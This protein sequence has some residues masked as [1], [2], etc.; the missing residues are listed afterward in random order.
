[1]FNTYIHA[2]NEQ[3]AHG[4]ARE[5]TYRTPFE[6]LLKALAPQTLPIHEGKRTLVGT[7]DFRVL[8]DDI[9]IGVIEC[10]DIGKNLDD[11][12]YKDQFEKYQNLGNLIITD[13]LQFRWVIEGEERDRVTIAEVHDGKIVP[14]ADNFP[15]LQTL[16]NGFLDARIAIVTSASDLAK[17]L[18]VSA[19]GIR[20]R[21]NA[22]LKSDHPSEELQG[23]MTAFREA[24]LPD[25]TVDQFAD[26]FAQT[27]VYGV[28][29]ARVRY[30]EEYP[31]ADAATDFP[32]QS[33]AQIIPPTNPFLRKLFRHMNFDLGPNVTWLM[34]NVVDQLALTQIDEIMADFGKSTAQHDPVV[35]FYETFLGEYDAKLREQRGVYYTPE[36]VVSYIVRSVD[37]ILKTQ[38]S[39]PD[40]LADDNTLILDPATG[41]GTFLHTV[42]EHIHDQF[43]QHNMLGEW[44]AYVRDHLLP[45]IFG[46]E[47][48]MAPYTVAHMKLG[49]QLQ[50]TGYQFDSD[51]R[52]GI[53]LTNTLEEGVRVGQMPMARFISDETNEA[54]AVKREKPIMV[55][56]GNPPY[57]INST[58]RSRTPSGEFTWIGKLLDDYYHIDGKPLG[59]RNPKALQDDYVKFI[60]F[61]QW[62]IEQSGM[63]V[64]AFINNHGFIDNPTFRGMRQQLINSF[65]SIYVLDLHGSTKKRE[66]TPEG[67][68]DDNV[69][70]IEPG[71]SINIFIKK[72]GVTSPAKIYH[73]DVWGKRSEKYEYLLQNG[74]D[75]TKWNHVKSD[76]PFYLLLPQDRANWDNYKSYLSVKDVFLESSNGFK[77]HRDHFAVAFTESEMQKQLSNLIDTQ[78]TDE[79]I[80]YRYNVNSTK[81]WSLSQTRHRLRED[82][83]WSKYVVN[84]LYR[85]L[86]PRYCLYGNYVMDRPRIDD[87]FH[88]LYSNLCV[89]IGRQGQAVGG[90]EWNLITVGEDVADTN[91]FYRGGIQYFPIYLYPKPDQLMDTDDSG[92]ELSDKGRRPNLSKPFV[93]DFSTKLGLSFVTEGQGDLSK[94]FGPEDVFYYAYAVFHSPT[95]RERYAEFLK[96]DFPRL[97]LTSDV[98]LFAA[99]VKLGKELVDYHLLRHQSLQG[100]FGLST[101]GFTAEKDDL[102]VENAT[103]KTKLQRYHEKKQ[104]V[105]INKTS[106]FTEVTQDDWDFYIGG[107]QVLDKW[108]KDRKDR[109]LTDDDI[110]HYKRI[111]IALRETRRLMTAIDESIGEFP[112]T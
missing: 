37:H 93:D 44:N 20:E 73:A 97:P 83:T 98:T 4:K 11:E 55:V 112:I 12:N 84:C 31:G 27:L 103:K 51:Q 21:I 74:I 52:L 61:A 106:Y 8:R 92:W 63:G 79:E 81:S 22:D 23:Q 34:N 33:L 40:G 5:H 38:F 29:A 99:L 78:L 58:N 17:K 9:Q 45:R 65:S 67:D 72:Q 60:R 57:N 102:K 35:H 89:A 71:V 107:Y 28:F 104:R 105:Y 100:R 16:Y 15:A 69:F 91:L 86:D 108:L 64:L 46:F 41:T 48:L 14:I 56:L 80:S 77:T 75:T 101:I 54:A 13:Y 2:L 109:T 39:R 111:V 6:N 62:R 32:R 24:L 53:Y 95:Y 96:I 7:P 66:K 49:L 1:M 42:V 43:T 50:R 3:Y 76:K 85:P 110:Q 10:K 68:K 47:L 19:R 87:L 90:D 88:A 25:M 36:P 94:T 82:D 18:A 59:E 70:N 30:A 26:M